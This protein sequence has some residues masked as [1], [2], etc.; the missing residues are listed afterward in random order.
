MTYVTCDLDMRRL[1]EPVYLERAVFEMFVRL[2]R[3]HNIEPDKKYKYRLLKHVEGWDVQVR[4][5]IV[6]PLE[7]IDPPG[8]LM[9]PPDR[10]QA[11]I[12]Q[13]QW[14]APWGIE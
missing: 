11:Y 2:H 7:R 1:R 12:D 4:L 13:V 5:E 10:V 3:A 9:L 6:D 14:N 8:A